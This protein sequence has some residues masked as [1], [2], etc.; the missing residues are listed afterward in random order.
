MTYHTFVTLTPAERSGRV[1]Q[2]SGSSVLQGCF[3]YAPHDDYLMYL[4]YTT[5]FTGLQ[6]PVT[7]FYKMKAW[8]QPLYNL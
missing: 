4:P 5:Y 8:I 3:G 7:S 2:L 1:A 6:K